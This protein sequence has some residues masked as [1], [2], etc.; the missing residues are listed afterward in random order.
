MLYLTSKLLGLKGTEA[1]IPAITQ[2][3]RYYVWRMRIITKDASSLLNSTKQKYIGEINEF[4]YK[5]F[6]W[7]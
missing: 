7:N 5:Y 4:N 6:I 1:L 2:I 3:T